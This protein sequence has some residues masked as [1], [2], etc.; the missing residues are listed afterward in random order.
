MEGAT[1]PRR[2]G[3]AAPAARG[4]GARQATDVANG[5]RTAGV[6]LLGVLS[7]A[8]PATA[9]AAGLRRDS[10]WLV[11]L[12]LALALGLGF[13]AGLW[14]PR[15]REA[16]GALVPYGLFLVAAVFAAV[17]GHAVGVGIVRGAPGP[18][19][20]LLVPPVAIALGAL[21]VAARRI[22]AVR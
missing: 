12:S 3:G 16:E 18:A 5:P 14:F 21:A 22:R 8:L 13:V 7:V 1:G 4:A 10:A 11:H 15:F 6:V 20:A 17:E 2:E 19:A 9:L